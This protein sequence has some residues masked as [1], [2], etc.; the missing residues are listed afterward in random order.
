M[1]PRKLRIVSLL[2]SLSA[3]LIVNGAALHTRFF[4]L[5]DRIEHFTAHLDALAALLAIGFF[6]VLAF[7]VAAFYARYLLLFRPS[8]SFYIA[9]VALAVDYYAIHRPLAVYIAAVVIA[10]IV[11]CTGNK[12]WLPLLLG[13]LAVD[14]VSIVSFQQPLRFVALAAA[15]ALSFFSLPAVVINAK[16]IFDGFFVQQAEHDYSLDALFFLTVGGFAW[17][18]AVQL[19]GACIGT[20]IFLPMAVIAPAGLSRT[21]KQPVVAIQRYAPLPPQIDSISDFIVSRV[22]PA[23]SHWDWNELQAYLSSSPR[24]EI[25]EEESLFAKLN[26]CSSAHR[27]SAGVRIGSV[28]VNPYYSILESSPST[29]IFLGEAELTRQLSASCQ[30]LPN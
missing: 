4:E 17:A 14:F 7:G 6:Y 21:I 10:I 26:T 24:T 22:L 5:K 16:S 20:A 3:L 11:G 30:S 8:I 15:A 13:L 29:F 19:F 9:S 2:P 25:D 18:Q 1:E 12:L 27:L 28:P 23:A